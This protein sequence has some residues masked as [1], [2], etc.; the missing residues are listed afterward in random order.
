MMKNVLRNI[1]IAVGRRTNLARA[2]LVIK[3]TH[4]FA[5]WGVLSQSESDGVHIAVMWI[6]RQVYLGSTQLSSST[7]GDWEVVSELE[8]LAPINMVRRARIRQWFKLVSEPD[9]HR[10]LLVLLYA[11]KQG[12]ADG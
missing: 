10:W 4:A 8:V 7:A 5:G 1:N 6:L 12:N 2:L 9:K 3:L 11:A